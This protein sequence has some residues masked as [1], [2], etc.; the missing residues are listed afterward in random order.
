MAA[1]FKTAVHVAGEVICLSEDIDGTGRARS[2][3][4]G[5]GNLPATIDLFENHRCRRG[6]LSVPKRW[7]D[8]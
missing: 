3:P 8:S 1:H 7:R 6:T 2:A 4:L 5:L